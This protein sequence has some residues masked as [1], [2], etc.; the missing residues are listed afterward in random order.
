M[1]EFVIYSIHGLIIIAASTVCY[2][3]IVVRKLFFKPP[4]KTHNT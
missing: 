4:T 2:A 3:V 1:S